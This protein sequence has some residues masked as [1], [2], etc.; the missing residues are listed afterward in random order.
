MAVYT[1]FTVHIFSR[2]SDVKSVC[3]QL[4]K[5][6]MSDIL[7]ITTTAQDDDVTHLQAYLLEGRGWI[8]LKVI[9][10]TGVKARFSFH[11]Y[12]FTTAHFIQ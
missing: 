4:C 3:N 6:F 9:Y 10:K 2:F 11:C 8:L 7:R 12:M 5:E 1:G